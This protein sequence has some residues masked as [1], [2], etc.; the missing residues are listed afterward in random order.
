MQRQSDR[1]LD[2]MYDIQ[3]HRRLHNAYLGDSELQASA[4]AVFTF[5]VPPFVDEWRT[6]A[7]RCFLQ[8]MDAIC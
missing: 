4:I 2:F 1:H 7:L 8:T 5:P 3:H 6:A